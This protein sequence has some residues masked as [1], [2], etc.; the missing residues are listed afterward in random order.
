MTDKAELTRSLADLGINPRGTL[1]VHL[2]YK[3]LGPVAGG[4]DTLLDALI[5][6]MA[7]GLLVLPAHTWANVGERNP[8][9]DVCHTPVCVGIVPELFRKRPGVLRSLHPTHSLSAYG[10]DAAAFVSGEEHAGSP[11]PEGFAYHKLWQRKAQILLIG[12]NF[13]RNTYIHGLEEWEG[14]PGTLTPD[15]LPMY[16]INEAG[17]RLA[18]PQRRHCAELGSETF[19]KLEEPARRH[20]FLKKG[21]LGAADCTLVD[22]VG[23]REVAARVFAID[24]DVLKTQQ[25]LDR[26]FD[27][28]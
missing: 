21:K 28:V 8:V 20:G 24:P 15:P 25:P 13:T 14:V 17:Q 12:V 2:S 7:P 27:G 23:L 4:P 22:A 6:W 10:A 1:M 16:V 9:M 26:R 18:T 11:C 3:S 19:W 5:A